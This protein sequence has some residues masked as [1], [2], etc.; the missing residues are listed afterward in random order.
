MWKYDTDKYYESLKTGDATLFLGSYHVDARVTRDNP[1]RIQ[2]TVTNVS[3]W[4]SATRT[5]GND[6]SILE[7]RERGG[8]GIHLGGNM[9]QT[10]KWS[11]ALCERMD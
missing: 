5:R 10:W 2:F 6:K 11:E 4:E 7:D 8:P 3:G 1:N 9:K